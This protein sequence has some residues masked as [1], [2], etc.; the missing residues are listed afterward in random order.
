MFRWGFIGSFRAD[1]GLPFGEPTRQSTTPFTLYLRGLGIRVKLNPPRSPT[2]NAKV[3]RTQGTTA[4]WADPK[5]CA[6]W[7]DL[8]E[9]L[10]QAV[11]DQRENYPSRACKNQTRA[12]CFPEIL[13]HPNRFNPAD[14]EMGRI[15][16]F[17]EKGVW[18]RKISS[19]G[20]AALFGKTYQIGFKHRNKT[21][22]ATFV[23]DRFSW[24]FKSEEGELLGEFPADNINQK[25][26]SVLTKLQRTS[27][28]L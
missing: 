11:I 25:E 16:K 17:L 9:K 6:D 10:N 12:A 20:G 14:F 2:K 24:V 18:T 13:H 1:N 21:A 8:Q 22:I 7:L 4:R 28:N 15:A 3:E 19:V 26:L 5:N 23:A 27:G